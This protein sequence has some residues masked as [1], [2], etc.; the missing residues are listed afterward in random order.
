MKPSSWSKQLRESGGG[1]SVRGGKK[2]LNHITSYLGGDSFERRRVGPTGRD[3]V[4]ARRKGERLRKGVLGGRLLCTYIKGVILEDLALTVNWNLFAAKTWGWGRKSNPCCERKK[5]E[6][7][8]IRVLI[9]SWSE[10]PHARVGATTVSR[11]HKRREEKRRAKKLD[12][13]GRVGGAKRQT[14]LF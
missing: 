13:I 14:T 3:G 1:K 10:T 5:E 8:R 9:L 11:P 6:K 2:E 7:Q 12:Q 4:A